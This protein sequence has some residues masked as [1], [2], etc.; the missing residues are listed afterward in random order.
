ML[1]KINEKLNKICTLPRLK[2]PEVAKILKE[3]YQ[4]GKKDQEKL[5]ILQMTEYNKRVK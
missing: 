3:C 4:Q 1:T 5:D 2:R